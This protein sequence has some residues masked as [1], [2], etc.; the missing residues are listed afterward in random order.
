MNNTKSIAIL[1][2]MGP[3]ASAR[4][5]QVMVDM[6]T[7][8]FGI[9][10][11]SK[12][13]ELILD[14]V[15]VPN[16]VSNKKNSGQALKVL[17]RR[18]EK[19][20]IFD[21]VCFGISCNTAHILLPKLQRNTAIPFISIIEEVAKEVFKSKLA[22]VGLLASPVTI[23]SRLYHE[24]LE[25]QGTKVVIPSKNQIEILD[26]VIRSVLMGEVD[27]DQVK[28]LCDIANSLQNRGAQGIIL[29]CTELPLI[30]PKDFDLP[31]FDSVEILAKALL[32][33]AVKGGESNERKR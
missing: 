5:V 11:D 31:V 28:N 1:G 32:H 25:K 10:V 13:P 7:N 22:S 30:F 16:F 2:G 18:V 14:S 12:F 20:E 23:S 33:K 15:P 9:E 24:E 3:Q 26:A 4:L 17:M 27:I 8:D 19:L 21:P 6:C 29:G